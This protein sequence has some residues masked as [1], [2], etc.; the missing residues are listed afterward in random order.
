MAS[1]EELTGAG[2]LDPDAA[3]REVERVVEG[4]PAPTPAERPLP[5]LLLEAMRPKKGT[6][7][8]FLSPG[9]FSPGMA[10]P[11]GAIDHPLLV[12]AAF[13]RAG[14]PPPPPTPPRAA[15]ADRHNPRT[16]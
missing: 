5:L 2:V 15:E 10:P 3:E 12:S 6:K 14:G 7:T 13:S 8:P 11:L 16:A 1:R 9:L 4:A